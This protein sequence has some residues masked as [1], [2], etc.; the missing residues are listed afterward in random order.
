MGSGHFLVAAV[1]RIERAFSGYLSRRSLPAV[2]RQLESLRATA[3]EALGPAGEQVEWRTPSSSGGIIAR[4][5]VYGVDLNPIAVQLA[6]LSL[7][8][9]TFV[10]G[11]SLSLLDHNLVRGNSLVGIGHVEEARQAIAAAGDPLFPIDPAHLL[12]QAQGSLIR[13]RKAMDE[14]PADLR[15]ARQALRAASEK[16]QP[17]AALFDLVTAAGWPGRASRTR[18]PSFRSW[19]RNSSTR[20]PGTAPCRPGRAPPISLPGRVPRGVPARASRAST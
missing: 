9:H 7:W 2:R 18:W 14:S 17:A 3:L 15:G 10:P 1:D 11:L 19:T 16:I 4:R 5:C 20:R 8:I 12:G 6:R 13:F